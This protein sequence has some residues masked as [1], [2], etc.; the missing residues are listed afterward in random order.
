L[1]FDA[2]KI[3]EYN[4]DVERAFYCSEDSNYMHEIELL[5]PFTL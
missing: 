4:I 3:L 1:K 5:T 2:A